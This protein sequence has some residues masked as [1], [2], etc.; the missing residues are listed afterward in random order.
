[1]IEK[2]NGQLR[3]PS[4]KALDGDIEIEEETKILDDNFMDFVENMHQK[5]CKIFEI[6]YQIV[7]DGSYV[8]SGP[9]IDSTLAESSEEDQ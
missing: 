4:G 1:M 2:V 8:P 7:I 5:I 9:V 6:S 3:L